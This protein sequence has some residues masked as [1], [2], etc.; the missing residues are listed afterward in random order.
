M[1]YLPNSF[2]GY[3]LFDGNLNNIA[4]TSKTVINTI[5]QYSFCVAER[6]DE[7]KA[8]LNEADILLPD[9]VGIVMAVKTVTGHDLKKISGAELHDHLLQRLNRNNGRC[10][11]LGSS[12]RTLQKIKARLE[13]EYP[14]IT[15]ETYSPPFKAEFSDEENAAMV[16]AVNAFKPDVVFVGMTA[17]KQEKW[18]H[19]YSKAI[20]TRF[21]CSIGAVFDF[22][23]GTVKRPSQFWINLGLEW[24]V[25]LCRE[26]KRM[27]KRYIYYGPI[28][29]WA[30][31]K[32]KLTADLHTVPSMIY[33]KEHE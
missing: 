16:D 13:K 3:K 22:Y 20:N 12:N 11:Y 2:M 15:C 7:F 9:G 19:R 4:G 21:I 6:D 23:A 32:E 27:W 29:A 26:P 25:R 10:F 8:A 17:P 28:F 33:S 18:V 5:N 1:D 14:G 24:F 30:L 31:L